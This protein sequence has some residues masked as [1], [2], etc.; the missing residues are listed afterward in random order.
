MMADGKVGIVGGGVM[1]RGIALLA[2]QHGHTVCIV[3]HV[4]AAAIQSDI[5]RQLER[6]LS[7]KKMTSEEKDSC[8]M[9][10]SVQSD[11]A[12]LHDCAIIIEAIVEDLATKRDVFVAL[13]GIVDED[14]LLTTNTS[15]LSVTAIAAAMAAPRR[16]VGMHFF[17][18]APVMRLVEIVHGLETEPLLSQRAAQWACDW[19]KKPVFSS[20]M[21]GF[22]VNRVARPFYCEALALLEAGVA[23]AD[24]IDA[25]LTGSGVF[26][27]GALALMDLIGVDTNL[28]NTVSLYNAY[29]QEKRYRPSP[30][31]REYVDGGRLGKKTGCGFYRYIEGRAVTAPH[32]YH[33]DAAP[34]DTVHCYAGSGI[35]AALAQRAN[36][37]I[38]N[39]DEQRLDID[40]LP[41]FISDGRYVA[42]KREQCG[43]PCVMA[44][45]IVCADKA[46]TVALAASADCGEREKNTA[47]GFFQSLGIDVIF[48]CD[49]PGMI[50]HRTVCLLINEA[51]FAVMQAVCNDADCDT[52]LADGM[53]FSP[54]P[55]T[56]A[57]NAGEQHILASLQALHA[58]TGEDKFR[59]SA[60]LYRR[61]RRAVTMKGTP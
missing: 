55:L 29:Y 42:D 41:L 21:P 54:P 61:A 38:G 44:D 14:C 53:R 15:T 35:A 51:L 22:I 24:D 25:V 40:G 36:I 20:S 1:G 28:R 43:K 13:E 7:K 32:L 16:L 52:A 50:V 47:A 2:L 37:A 23:T 12:A 17:N 57:R 10:L 48:I 39:S 30:L 34:P 4:A 58:C 9:R 27:M 59:P 46:N 33:R 11:L 49:T 5:S 31:Q 19:Q 6:L 18:P 8:L 45:W 3:D 56:L 60:E 26:P